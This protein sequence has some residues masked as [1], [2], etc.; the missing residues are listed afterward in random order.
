MFLTFAREKMALTS[1]STFDLKSLLNS[2]TKADDYKDEMAQ[3]E[4]DTNISSAEPS[5]MPPSSMTLR[6]QSKMKDY[7][8][9]IH[10]DPF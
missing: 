9:G 1:E 5:P 4:D 6:A 3:I 8:K 7:L 2:S 10:W